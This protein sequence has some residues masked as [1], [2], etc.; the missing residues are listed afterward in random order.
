MDPFRISFKPTLKQQEYRIGQTMH[1]R[2]KYNLVS[3]IN[4]PYFKI[5]YLIKSLRYT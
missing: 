2:L 4:N 3:D 5:F 1:V